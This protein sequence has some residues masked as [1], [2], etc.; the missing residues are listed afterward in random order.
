MGFLSLIKPLNWAFPT[1]YS[2]PGNCIE[3][4]SSPFPII[5]G[6]NCD[7]NFAK[8][9]LFSEYAN[10]ETDL[11]F[12]FIDD[13]YIV[14]SNKIV[15]ET[16]IPSFNLIFKELKINYSQ[17]FNKDSP[18]TLKADFSN[19]KF[20][21]KKKSHKSAKKKEFRT[22]LDEDEV[23]IF[24]HEIRDIITTNLIDILPE[25]LEG[26]EE[27]RNFFFIFFY[28]TREFIFSF[29]NFFFFNFFE[30]IF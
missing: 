3:M 24:L 20:K 18:K 21:V 25:T 4:L 12:V 17:M 26:D 10:N 15:K 29:M 16:Q 19:R 23:L 9:N 28:E 2:L 8:N 5:C 14:A 6:I 7:Y 1:I 11:I 30:N 22:V 13:D 27:V